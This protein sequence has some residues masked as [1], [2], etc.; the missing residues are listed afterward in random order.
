MALYRVSDP[1]LVTRHSTPNEAAQA[2]R[3][4]RSN[5][6]KMS[7]VEIDCECLL[8]VFIL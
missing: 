8:D 2:V 7:A 1:L 5:P 4:A 6:A 3:A